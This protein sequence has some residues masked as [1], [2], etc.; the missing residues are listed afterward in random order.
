VS[1]GIKGVRLSDGA[2]SLSSSIKDPCIG[3]D[4]ERYIQDYA[5]PDA[6]K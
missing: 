6:K 3:A 1:A 5:I 4:W 2:N